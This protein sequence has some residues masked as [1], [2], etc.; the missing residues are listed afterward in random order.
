MN[1]C[2]CEVCRATIY[3]P[4]E[5]QLCSACLSLAKA[6]FIQRHKAKKPKVMTPEEFKARWDSDDNGGGI[7]YDDIAACA[8]EWG[9]AARPKTMAMDYV[10]ALVLKEAGCKP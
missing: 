1:A 8:K 10:K 3:D 5:E 4:D 2:S 6:E 9:I 7:T